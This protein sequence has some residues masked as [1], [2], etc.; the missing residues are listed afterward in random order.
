MK[1]LLGISL[2]MQKVSN[3]TPSC[4]SV[5]SYG[6]CCANCKIGNPMNW[7]KLRKEDKDKVKES[8]GR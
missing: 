1:K 3:V 4:A 7:H 6:L 8:G 5:M 2:N